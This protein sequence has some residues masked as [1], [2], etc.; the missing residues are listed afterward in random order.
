MRLLTMIGMLLI[1]GLFGTSLIGCTSVNQPDPYNYEGKEIESI[2]YTTIDYFGDF[3][4]VT[5]L[6]LVNGDVLHRQFVSS[7]EVIPEFDVIY[8]F[9]IERVDSFLDEFGA[10]GIFDL[11]DEYETNE[12]IDDG[13]G[14]I[15]VIN[16]TDGTSKTSTG[17]NS[18]PLDIFEKA[19]IATIDLYGE[20]L[21]NTSPQ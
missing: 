4:N 2:E 18:W 14:W 20:D 7:D 10:S 15:L 6:D 8:T 5:V 9:E 17:D 21:F 3:R 13:G 16:Y 19:D 1:V 12:Q 11:E